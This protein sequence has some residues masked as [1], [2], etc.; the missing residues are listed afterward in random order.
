MKASL[1]YLFVLV[2]GT[3]CFGQTTLAY[4][5]KKDAI[6]T[7]K[8]DAHQ[9]ITQNLDGTTH[10][11]TNTM[12]GIL[13]FRVIGENADHYEIAMRFKDLN[14]TMTSNLEG[15]LLN[16][17][18]AELR[19][20]DL[21]SQIF[22]SMLDTPVEITLTKTGDI[23]AVRGGDNLVIKMT[24]ASGIEDA[25]ALNMMETSLLKEF[26]SEAL[27]NNYEQMTFIYPDKVLK[28]GDSWENE[29]LGKLN[30][31]NKWTLN[32]ISATM[33]EISGDANVVLDVNDTDSAMRL[34]G[35]QKTHITTDV[36]SGFVRSM[37]VESFSDGTSTIAQLGDQKIPTTIKSTITYQLI[38]R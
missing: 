28:V 35:T 29:Y 30:A 24:K 2:F 10:E 31:K 34:S 20:G 11:I 6:F 5:L 9:V 8:Q 7:I 12:D 23:V 17:K 25:V 32:A 33:A 37:T 19:K 38:N 1:K 27:S 16:V 21:Q 4:H 14:L 26:G 13:E 36:A 3:I 15:E 22:N 18:A